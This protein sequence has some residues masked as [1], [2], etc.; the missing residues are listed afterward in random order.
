MTILSNAHLIAPDWTRLRSDL[1][2]EG[3]T[4]TEI[5]P[6]LTPNP[7]ERVVDLS[8]H[9]IVPGLVDAHTHLTHYRGSEEDSVATTALRSAT[10]AKAALRAGITTVRDM[11]SYR[12]IDVELR[13]SI[14]RGDVAGPRMICAGSYI[15]MT[16]GHGGSRSRVADGRDG[17]R[18]AA[19]E[20]LAGGSDFLKVMCS[21]GLRGGHYA[22]PQLSEEEIRSVVEVARDAGTNVAAHAHP[23]EAIERAVRAGVATIEH[24]SFIDESTA[25]LMLERG[26]TLVPTF[27]VY[28]VYA[29]RSDQ[30]DIVEASRA[31]MRE[32]INA[33]LMA[34]DKG[35]KW[36]VGSDCATMAPVSALIDE[37]EFL[38]KEIGMATSQVLAQATIGNSSILALDKTGMIE[39]GC[40]S[41]LVA[42]IGNPLTNIE[43]LRSVSLTVAE[44]RLFDWRTSEE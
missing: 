36:A 24:G 19:R 44:G 28:A 11:G 14:R 33:F 7:S 38:V 20:Q 26:T 9:T 42:V 8:G 25:E 39:V 3:D 21:G 41:D 18:Q 2:Y 31:I 40:R 23:S 43:S 4:I 17:L 35:V 32:K 22:N 13:E 15:A 1:R 12:R 10:R 34:V 37:I 5:G 6:H 29:S 16:G 27:A 30:P